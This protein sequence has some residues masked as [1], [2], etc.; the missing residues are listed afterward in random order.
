[1]TEP[2][3]LK[4]TDVAQVPAVRVMTVLIVG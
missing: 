3:K 2:V 4:V 1:V